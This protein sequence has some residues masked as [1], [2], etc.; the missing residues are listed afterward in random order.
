[1]MRLGAKAAEPLTP[2]DWG[3][4]VDVLA[5]GVQLSEAAETLGLADLQL[6]R[7]LK[8]HPEQARRAY[9]LASWQWH[10]LC[11]RLLHQW[12]DL[13][14]DEIAARCAEMKRLKTSWIFS[15]E[16]RWLLANLRRQR[17]QPPGKRGGAT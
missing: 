17:Q 11:D 14:V 16:R 12:Q 3:R 2:I 7:L 10:T 13:S 1:M 4:V 8:E 6:V 15:R 9:A 5:S